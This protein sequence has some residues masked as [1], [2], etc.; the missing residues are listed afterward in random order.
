M[1]EKLVTF[2]MSVE[3]E[4]DIEKLTIVY[5][6]DKSK[7]MRELLRLGIQKKKIEQSLFLYQE[8]KVSLWKAASLAD[9]SLWKMIDILKEK[10]IN[11]QYGEKEISEDFKA[12]TE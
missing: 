4:K 1:K 10:K 2:R 11:L 7:L 3:I 6:T 12:L 9:V 5:D 8:G